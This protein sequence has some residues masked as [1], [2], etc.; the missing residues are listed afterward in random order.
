MSRLTSPIDVDKNE[1]KGS[2]APSTSSS[3]SVI[4]PFSRMMALG[5]LTVTPAPPAVVKDTCKRPVPTYNDRYN[6]FQPARD[7][8]P[9]DYSPYAHGEP[10]FDDMPVIIANLPK[11][12]TVARASKVALRQ[13]V[14]QLG[15]TL[16]ELTTPKQPTFGRVNTVS[17]M[18]SI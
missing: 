15:Y 16:I 2:R 8:L 14:W 7:D 11:G 18:V 13:W 6:P 17:S 1:P 5:P 4:N 3:T 12:K 9:S 10:Y